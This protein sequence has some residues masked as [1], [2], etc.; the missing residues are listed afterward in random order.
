MYRDYK[1]IVMDRNTVDS[2]TCLG[3]KWG[4]EFRKDWKNGHRGSKFSNKST[5]NVFKEQKREIKKGC[6]ASSNLNT[7]TLG[8]LL[9]YTFWEAKTT[10][11]TKLITLAES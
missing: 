10:V 11:I 2:I 9:L 8:M 7:T 1:I 4:F 6:E 3:S 5:Q